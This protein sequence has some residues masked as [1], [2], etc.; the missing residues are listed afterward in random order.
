V[1]E[2]RRHRGPHPEDLGLFAPACQ[3]LLCAAAA[4]L[5]WLLDRGY[6]H[7]SSLK[8]VGDRH[9]LVARQRIAVSRCTCSQADALG[10]ARRRVEVDALPD[11]LLLVDAYNVLTTIE[12]ALSGGFILAARDG[13]FR[14]MASMHGSYRKVSETMPALRLLGGTLAEWRVSEVVWLLDRPVSNSG[15]LKQMMDVLAAKCGWPWRVELVPDPDRLLIESDD[16]AATADSAVLDR[17]GPWLNLA[18]QTTVSHIPQALIV[19]LSGAT[20]AIGRH[21]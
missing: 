7:A 9:G 17:C 11:R 15:R 1:P 19:D 2:R 5:A 18:R 16:I 4:D 13:T 8:L 10:R 21:A 3:P 20:A 6:P 12:A 14:D